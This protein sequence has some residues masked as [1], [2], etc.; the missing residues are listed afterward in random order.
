M[1]ELE[2]YAA[3]KPP[4]SD[5]NSVKATHKYLSACHLIFERG[6]LNPDISV[7]KPDGLII[8]R[9]NE[10][11]SFFTNWLDGLLAQGII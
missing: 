2:E 4:P 10:G 11:Y 5:A 7:K 6:I 3:R 9:M 8:R 1:A